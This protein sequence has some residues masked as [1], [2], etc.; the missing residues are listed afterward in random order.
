MRPNIL[1]QFEPTLHFCQ[2]IV[3]E[4][5]YIGICFVSM[6]HLFAISSSQGA[7]KGSAEPF[8]HPFLVAWSAHNLLIA[9][10]ESPPHRKTLSRWSG[11][12]MRR[13]GRTSQS[14]PKIP[15]RNL[16]QSLHLAHLQSATLTFPPLLTTPLS[17]SYI[18]NSHTHSY[19]TD[20][21]YH[22][23]H[24]RHIPQTTTP[25][26]DKRSCSH[27]I[28]SLHHNDLNHVH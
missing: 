24:T 23:S 4:C 6:F 22:H 26:K 9:L 5:Q 17:I 21:L 19:T 27:H 13:Y 16:Q 11:N 20:Y 2:F 3:F 25:E 1:F 28:D 12:E 7:P 14:P 18:A 10:P 8:T 15:S